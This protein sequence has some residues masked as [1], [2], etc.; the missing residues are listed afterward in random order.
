M[1]NA[2]LYSSATGAWNTPPDLVRAI[3]AFM[4]RLDL[5]PCADPEHLV[6]AGVHYDGG[7]GRDGLVLPWQVERVYMNP[8]YG[9][10]IEPWIARFCTQ[11]FTEG[12]ALVP[13]RTDTAWFQPLHA[14][15]VCYIRGRLHFSGHKDSAPFPSCLAYRGARTAA[16]TAAF[17]HRG[18]I[19]RA[20][21][22]EPHEEARA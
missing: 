11:P 14:L 10:A 9:R 18:P 19:V 5:D 8:P 16:F 2:S 7:P 22:C 17:R 21:P 15:P 6:P 4:G 1:V 20:V 12:I 3:V 13:A